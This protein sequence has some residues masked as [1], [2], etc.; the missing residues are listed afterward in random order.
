MATFSI[1]QRKRITVNTDPQRRC[2]S[3]CHAK[4]EMQWTPWEELEAGWTAEA[5]QRRLS[6]WRDLNDYAIGERGESA[7]KEYRITEE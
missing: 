2:Y 6:F 1:E 5:A 4:S 7:R 3:G